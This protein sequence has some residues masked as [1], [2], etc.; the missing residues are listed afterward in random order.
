MNITITRRPI[1]EAPEWVRDAWVGLSLPTVQK[2]ARSWP[3]LG[4]VSGPNNGVL[5]LWALL[6]GRTIRVTGYAVNA[7]AAV[8]LLAETQPAAAQ[9]WRENTPELISRNRSFVFDAGACEQAD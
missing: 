9:W 1:G 7:R 4:V 6:R 3:G 2:R 8:D 5:Q